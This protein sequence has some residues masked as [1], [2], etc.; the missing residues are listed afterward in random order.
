GL[1]A[2]TRFRAQ[3]AATGEEG[4]RLAAQDQPRAVFLD[5]DLPDLS[6]LE[7]MQRL[8]A[9]ERTRHIPIIVHTAKVLDPPERERRARVPA[10]IL[11]KE[12]R[13]REAA[14]ARLRGALIL[15]GLGS[16]PRG[17]HG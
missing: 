1:L 6:G 13:S 12:A 15:A 7:V 9:G 10:A 3:E 4:L 8:R 17:D 14:R 16:G 2:D 11:P 5:L